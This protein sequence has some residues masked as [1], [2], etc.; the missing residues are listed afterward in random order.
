MK[1]V[2]HQMLKIFMAKALA[3]ILWPVSLKLLEK[4]GIDCFVNVEFLKILP[5]V[6]I[7]VTLVVYYCDFI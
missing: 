3:F 6:M 5:K 1:G 2:S 7:V 4:F